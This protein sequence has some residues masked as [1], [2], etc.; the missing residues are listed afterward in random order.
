M[1]S[2]THNQR[3]TALLT[4]FPRGWR[5][6]GRAQGLSIVLALFLVTAIA[7]LAGARFFLDATDSP[8]AGLESIAWPRSSNQTSPQAQ[9]AGGTTTVSS[10]DSM[11]IGLEQ[12]LA[13]EP[14]DSKGWALLAQ[15][16]AFLG[17]VP[18]AESALSRAVELG[19]DEKDLRNRIKLASN[20]TTEPGGR[21]LLAGSVVIHGMV[22]LVSAA[23]LELA[24]ES[25]LF[26]TAK[27]TDGSTVPVAVLGQQVSEF[28]YQFELSEKDT[29]M[30]GVKL[31]DF[32]E[33]ALSARISRSGTAERSDSDLESAVKVIRLGESGWVDLVIENR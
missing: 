20:K 30:P 6:A 26:V 23:P 22:K 25:R 2:T 19:F 14:G 11:I 16:H 5:Q 21:N 18:Q 10:V 24:P 33:I 12:R 29:M 28:P 8:I 7:L 9:R 4:R 32:D 1:R 15:S 17:N 13:R 31:A 27:T 3:A